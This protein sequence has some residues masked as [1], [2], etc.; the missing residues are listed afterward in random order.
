M[1]SSPKSTS[2]VVKTPRPSGITAPENEKPSTVGPAVCTASKYVEA[3]PP[4]APLR[5]KPSRSDV[6]SNWNPATGVILY[7]YTS[8]L[9]SSFKDI[10]RVLSSKQLFGSVSEPLHS[11][12]A[13]A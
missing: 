11:P 4:L 10:H 7:I 13:S 12:Q 9:P 5:V 3:N 1:G 2:R 6:M 8:I